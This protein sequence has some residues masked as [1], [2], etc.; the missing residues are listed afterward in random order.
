MK[1]INQNKNYGRQKKVEP[2]KESSG[3]GGQ[4]KST[5]DKQSGEKYPYDIFK[6]S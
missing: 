1:M 2:K 5:N 3:S 4:L 6:S